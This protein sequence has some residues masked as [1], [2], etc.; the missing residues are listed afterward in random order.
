MELIRRFVNGPYGL[1]DCIINRIEISSDK[2][3]LIFDEGFHKLD[4]DEKVK[5]QIDFSK[6]DLDFC[7]VYLFDNFTQNEG[8]FNGEKMSLKTFVERYQ[9]VNIEVI[10]YTYSSYNT[11]INGYLHA[12]DYM[13]EIS[14]QIFNLGNTVYVEE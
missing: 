2:I 13:T 10:D 9:T 6:A 3:S 7:N 1:H 5:G 14:L 4:F 8:K 12:E 11:V